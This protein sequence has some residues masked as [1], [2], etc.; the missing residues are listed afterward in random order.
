MS[1]KTIVCGHLPGTTARAIQNIMLTPSNHWS[2][3]EINDGVGNTIFTI[4]NIPGMNFNITMTDTSDNKI[5]L[6]VNNKIVSLGSTL[7][8]LEIRLH[9]CNENSDFNFIK[10]MQDTI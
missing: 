4:G 2:R 1:F 3:A 9:M 6:L 10:F 8:H 7:F 5:V